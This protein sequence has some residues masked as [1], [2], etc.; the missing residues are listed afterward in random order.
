MDEAKVSQENIFS[1]PQNKRKGR[2]RKFLKTKKRKMYFLSLLT[3]AVQITFEY[4][5]F[6]EG[7]EENRKICLRDKF[8]LSFLCSRIDFLRVHVDT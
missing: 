3:N 2:I 4:D 8:A 6:G 1:F 7:I 5:C